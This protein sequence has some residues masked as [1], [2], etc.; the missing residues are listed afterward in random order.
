MSPADVGL[1]EALE[2]AASA[3]PQDADAI[4]PANGDPVQLAQALSDTE[5]SR[6]LC[7]LLGNEPDQMCPSTVER[8]RQITV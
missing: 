3:L 1:P 4:R 7:W 2:R 8:L 5:A 6:V